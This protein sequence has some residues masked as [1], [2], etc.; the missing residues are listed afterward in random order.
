MTYTNVENQNTTSTVDGT[1]TVELVPPTSTT[2][3]TDTENGE[4]SQKP[5][6][7][8][9]ATTGTNLDFSNT[10]THIDPAGHSASL[11]H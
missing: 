11:P 7:A 2:G 3:E 10:T 9:I 1:A 6:P 4:T 5:D 8:D